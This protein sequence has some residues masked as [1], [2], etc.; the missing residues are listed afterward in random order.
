MPA[1]FRPVNLRREQD[2]PEEEPHEL[3]RDGVGQTDELPQR[4]ERLRYTH[5]TRIPGTLGIIGLMKPLV[6]FGI[7]AVITLMFYTK[8][9]E[10]L[11]EEIE[12]RELLQGGLTNPNS[13]AI[14]E[15]LAIILAFAWI[16]VIPLFAI[17]KLRKQP[18]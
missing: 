4:F 13:R 8:T 14:Y 9:S 1:V 10:S 15:F 2:H 6:L 17:R 18:P 16:I 3:S 12:K 7:Y 5:P 11:H